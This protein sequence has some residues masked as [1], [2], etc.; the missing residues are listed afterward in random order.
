MS[1]KADPRSLVSRRFKRRL[2]CIVIVY[3]ST[4]LI[5][6][7]GFAMKAA[8]FRPRPQPAGPREPAQV[9]PEVMDLAAGKPIERELKAG[10][11]HIY[12][13]RLDANQLLRAIVDQRGIDVVVRALAPDGKQIVEVDGPNGANGPEPVTL[14]SETAGSY[15]LEVRAFNKEGSPGRYE[16]KIEAPGAATPQDHLRLA[17]ESGLAQAAQLK[18]QGTAEALHKAISKY[19]ELLPSWRSL[20]DRHKEAFTLND[21]GLAYYLLDEKQKALEYYGQALLIRQSI[22]DREG[23]ATTLGNLGTIY[24]AWGEKQKALEYF[25]QSLPIA[26]SVGDRQAEATTLNNLGAVYDSFGE[27]RKALEYYRQS[28]P[29]SQAI[30]DRRLEVALL[31][32]MG[33][34]YNLLGERQQA[35]EYY[36]QALLL[37]RAI[38]DRRVEGATLSN[39]GTVYASLGER[40]KALEY[41][42]Q[43]LPIR[44]LVGDQDGTASTLG[45]IGSIYLLL[46]ERQK[47]LEYFHQTL[48]I[49]RSIRDQLGEAGTVNNIGVVY[50][51][52]GEWQKA[53][54][55]YNQALPLFRSTGS[56]GGE[57]TTL[58]NIGNVYGWLGELRKALAYYDQALPIRRS[59]GD[60]EGEANTLK[61][62]GSAYYRL[63]ETQPANDFYAQSLT[64]CRKIAAPE[65]EAQNLYGIARVRLKQGLFDEAHANVEAALHIV[66]SLRTKVVSP[67]LRASYFA[68]VQEYYSFYIDLLMQRH[69]RDGKQ[70]YDGLAL[71]A[72]ERARARSLLEMLAEARADIRQAADPA[73]RERERSLQFLLDA[74]SERLTRLLSGKH[75]DQQAADLRKEVEQLLTQYQE[76]LAQIRDRSPQY[77]ALTQPQPLNLKQIQQEVVDADTLLLIYA[78]GDARSYL[79]AVTPDSI[80]SFTLP[81]REPIEQVSRRV[82]ELLTLRNRRV[83]GVSAAAWESQIRRAETAYDQA[84]RELSRMVLGPPAALFGKKRLVIVADGALHYVPFAALPAPGEDGGRVKHRPLAK[85]HQRLLMSEHEILSLPS[86][87]SLLVLR[88]ELAGRKP[89]PRAAMVLADPVFDREDAR[90][91]ASVKRQIT[92][93]AKTGDE[94]AGLALARS[95]NEVGLNERGELPRL[96]FT[97]QEA[98]A[99]YA[100]TRLAGIWKAVDFEASRATVSSPELSQYRILHFATHGL[101]NNEH[102]ELSGIVLSL[103]DREGRPQNGFWR[104]YDIY[105][106]KLGADIVVLSACQTALGKLIKGE[107]LVGLTRGFMYAGAARVVASLWRVEDEATAELMKK[108]YEGMIRD[109]LRPGEALRSAQVWMEKQKRWRAPY[110]WAGFVLQGEWR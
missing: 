21:I 42:N 26:R 45:H 53:L 12:R 64:L 59:V 46:G 43:A 38:G 89:A 105:N 1:L 88:K 108:F 65:L 22:G 66:E 82:C 57:A 107:G 15:R 80:T 85:S 14:I 75:T 87:S 58:T 90:V 13:V 23:E 10:E 103:I 63:G 19:E 74:K 39:L 41:Y 52:L 11:L 101:L 76:V 106:M 98:E 69:Q 44:Q 94:I 28:L 100:L 56:R 84:A 67:Q 110:Y 27:K 54:E 32:N 7:N 3:L 81:G 2:P 50:E 36:D 60:Q 34:A 9:N 97:R 5:F 91:Q 83:K 4:L 78:L 47:A 72:S 68:T 40:Q 51:F 20:G 30:G 92:K 96:P 29:L 18:S 6:G 61:N 62:I 49:Q 104:L 16:V 25:T 95:V 33:S 37:S 17:A 86:A 70:G 55:Y 35:L 24:I 109:G 79:W 71:Q 102:P 48:T 99:I 73:L 8:G 93:A 77:A 31:A